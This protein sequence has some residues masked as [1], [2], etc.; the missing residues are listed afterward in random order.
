[1]KTIRVSEKFHELLAAH[2]REGETMEETLRRMV[3]GPDPAALAE[4]IGTDEETAAR[5]R[6]AIERRRQRGRVRRAE[7]WSEGG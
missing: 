2:N 6:A 1:M 5:V 4:V 7:L 3:G